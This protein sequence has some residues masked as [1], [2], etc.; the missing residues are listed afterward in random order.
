MQ[1]DSPAE[2]VTKPAMVDETEGDALQKAETLAAEGEQEAALLAFTAAIEENPR[3]Y[4]AHM[5]MG[6]IYRER[7]EYGFA[8][9]SY[10][11][12]VDSSPKSYDAHYFL[13]LA[14]QLADRLGEAIR[15]YRQAIV[16][17]PTSH[18]ANLNLATAYLQ[19]DQAME[20][21]PFASKAAE[22]QPQHGPTHVNLATIHSTLGKH[23]AAVREYQIAAEL[24]DLEPTIILNM[25]D[26]LRV[27]KR[28]PE[29]I[30]AIQAVIRL[31]ASPEAYER[32]GFAYFKVRKYDDSI[33]AYQNALGMDSNY[34]PAM[35]GLAVNLL[36]QYIRSNRVDLDA[37]HDAIQHL[38][39]SLQIEPDQSRIVDLLSRYGQ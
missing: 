10:Q 4:R 2:I 14:L 23:E 16:L 30:N 15:S 24:I 29:M 25:A 3:L 26:S 21:L 34:Y 17:Q 13:G 27:L 39:R 32:L 35:N 1:K 6:E 8:V 7:G 22:L 18:E 33:G 37:R 36:N 9:R 19:T 31:E 12:A 20:A 28:Y 11:E 38:R 5:G